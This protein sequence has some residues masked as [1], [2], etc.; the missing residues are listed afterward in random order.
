M[1]SGTFGET[2]NVTGCTK[3]EN[4]SE[5]DNGNTSA[6]DKA[7]CKTLEASVCKS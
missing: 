5:L 1:L 3:T 2:G 6:I 4:Q 7:E